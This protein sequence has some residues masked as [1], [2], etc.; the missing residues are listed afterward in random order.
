MK[1]LHSF[2][3][4]RRTLDISLE[5]PI[6]ETQILGN[7]PIPNSPEKA[8]ALPCESPLLR[9]M[10]R[11]VSD[12]AVVIPDATR[13][14]QDVPRMTQAIRR[15]LR[16]GGRMPVTW[17]IGGGQHRLPTKNEI[18]MLLEDIPLSGD[19]ILCHDSTQGVRTGDV[20]S[21][22]T[23]VILHQS[24][25]RADLIVPIGGIAYHDL[26]GFS[27]GRKA[28]LPGISGAEAI[29]HNHALSLVGATIAS[30][31]QCGA[32]KGNPVAEDME[33]YAQI[34][35]SERKG[36]LL[37]VIPDENGNPYC[38]VA[39]DPFQAWLKGTELAQ[40]L[41]TLW[42]SE[43]ASLVLVSCGGYP[44]DIDL[45]QS[46]KA[47]SAVLHALDSKGGLVL[48]AGLEDGA[49][50]GTFGEDFRLA[51]EEPERAMQKLQQ[52]FSIPAFIASKIVADLK[53]HP[54]A[55]V[56]DRSDLPFPGEVFT[57]EKE[58]LEW[59]EKKIPVGPALCVPA[60]NC[61]TVRRK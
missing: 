11:E 6:L 13:S 45:Y 46:T 2:A 42:I 57:N 31:V 24:V 60:G 43:K 7:R 15:E 34:V 27:G 20:T 51:I 56:S 48:F 41:Q 47:I 9:N 5:R 3:L 53:G 19:K 26:A 44:Y 55:L 22:G 12:I 30:S 17:I 4:G 32:L 58:A 18:Q 50:P 49:G 59:I 28:L 40:Q 1:S 61:V 8:L 52:N 23:P 36:F 38:Y 21:R 33:E 29:Q 10:A 39:G 25:A 37:N 16:E 14:W 54:A 35:F